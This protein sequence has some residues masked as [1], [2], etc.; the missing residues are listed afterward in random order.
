MELTGG[1]L[2]GAVRYRID[3]PL[4]PGRSCHC[5]RCRKAFSG[6]ASAY[7]E[8]APGSF[9]WTSGEANIRTYET[10]PGWGLAFC[11]TCGTTLCGLEGERVHGVTLG[12][13]DGDPGVAVE[14]HIFV[15]SRA[16]WDHIGG[17]APQYAEFPPSTLPK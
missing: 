1:C 12:S 9:G 16:P 3:A 7:S 4:G 17:D 15:D 2:C 8:V 13:V 11:G 5:S 14:M 6:A 10:A